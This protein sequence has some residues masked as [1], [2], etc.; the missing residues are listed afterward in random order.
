LG[1]AAGAEAAGAVAGAAVRVGGV[2]GAG[3]VVVGGGAAVVVSAAVVVVGGVVVDVVDG[4]ITSED[5]T[6]GRESVEL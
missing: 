1:H 6:I 5:E 2:P 3:A 4:R